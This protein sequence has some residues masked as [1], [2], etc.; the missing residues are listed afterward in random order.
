MPWLQTEAQNL[1]TSGQTSGDLKQRL[2]PGSDLFTAASDCQSDDEARSL[3][4]LMELE[5]LCKQTKILFNANTGLQ[6]K[7]SPT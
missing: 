5:L 1:H 6:T 2:T 4:L 3:L 7:M